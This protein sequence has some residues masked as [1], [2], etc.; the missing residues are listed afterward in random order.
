MAAINGFEIHFLFATILIIAQ[1]I[2][3]DHTACYQV[4]F[5][6]NITNILYVTP[7]SL[8]E[9]YLRCGGN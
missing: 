6:L 7:C 9:L 8:A 3:Q 2:R 4:V 1:S 5:L